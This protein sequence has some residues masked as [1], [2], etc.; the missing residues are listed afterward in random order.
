[1]VRI[2]VLSTPRSGNT[3][4]R[5]MLAAG[6]Q[7]PSL[8]YHE[9]SDSEWAALPESFTLQMHCLPEPDLLKRFHDHN[10]QLL[11]VARH[12]LD[13]LIS[14]LHVAVY[15]VESERWLQGI[16]GDER[17]LFGGRPRSRE[18]AEYAASDR[19]KA[20]LNVTPA[21]WQRSD[22]Y[23]VRY[24]DLVADPLAGLKKFEQQFGPFK[25][26]YE[27]ILQ[28]A[29]MDTARKN[30]TNNHFWKGQ[31][32]LW[33]ELLPPAE[34]TEIAWHCK[35]ILDAL[36]YDFEPNRELTAEKADRAWVSLTG[37]ELG[38][39]LRKNS[40]GHVQ[41]IKE[42]VDRVNVANA[43]R[44][45]ATAERDRATTERDAASA[46]RDLASARADAAEHELAKARAESE[47]CH[48]EWQA[49]AE[50]ERQLQVVVA[51]Q[52]ARLGELEL[53]LEKQAAEHALAARQ[54]G[55]FV[56]SVR[57]EL[58]AA[59][60]R[61]DEVT[62]QNHIANNIIIDRDSQ[63]TAIQHRCDSTERELAERRADLELAGRE[64]ENALAAAQAADRRAV[65]CRAELTDARG[66][67]HDTRAERD[68][69]LADL[70][71]LQTTAAHMG[72]ELDRFRGL[73][74]FSIRT[75]WRIQNLRDR[76][77]RVF[78]FFKGLVRA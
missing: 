22:T 10:I 29:S 2:A 53:L 31:P 17:A 13:V 70:A 47:R 20:L 65:V 61:I 30:S 34:A 76:L 56:D 74:A 23:R 51:G 45:A 6:Y 21:W 72:R 54:A 78:G 62:E 48:A 67:L 43:E 40:V 19:A 39:T 9:M 52:Q 1:M 42:S 7:L 27:Q 16:H 46:A 36:G 28:T 58:A 11:T 5:I 26:S 44:D 33:R 18:F 41:Q 71:K 64:I 3:W 49:A 77:P 60:A 57:G 25:S 50:R 35:P 4:V 24:E 55:E 15:D 63:L 69:A 75:A 37:A 59:N 66:E 73:Q 12:P 68:K 8:A 14:I 38:R 32:G